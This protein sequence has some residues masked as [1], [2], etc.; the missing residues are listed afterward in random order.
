MCSCGM[1]HMDVAMDSG[2]ALVVCVIFTAEVVNGNEE[3]FS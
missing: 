2:W 3:L 1:K